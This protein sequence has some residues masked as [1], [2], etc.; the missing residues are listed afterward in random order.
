MPQFRR[1]L[2]ALPERRTVLDE[3]NVHPVMALLLIPPASYAALQC[4]D[5]SSWH[6]SA[7]MR[8][9]MAVVLTASQLNDAS[10]MLRPLQCK[11][12]CAQDA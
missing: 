6:A 5:C 8:H 10:G 7:Q 3:Q 9:T 1:V 12:Y 2:C 11:G 4:A